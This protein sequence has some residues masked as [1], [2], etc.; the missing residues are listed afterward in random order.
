MHDIISSDSI[1][2]FRSAGLVV[3]ENR[4]TFKVKVGLKMVRN[5]MNEQKTY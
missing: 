4:L 3:L 5:V 2:T 1:R